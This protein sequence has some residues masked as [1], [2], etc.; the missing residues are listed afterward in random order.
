MPCCTA[1]SRQH[2]TGQAVIY[3]AIAEHMAMV[4]MEIDRVLSVFIN[5]NTENY[6]E[7][8]KLPGGGKLQG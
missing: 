3:E 7:R 8:Y 5:S 2:S 6:K 4:N 1:R